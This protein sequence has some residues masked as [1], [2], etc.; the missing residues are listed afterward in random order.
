MHSIEWLCFRADAPDVQLS[1]GINERNSGDLQVAVASADDYVAELLTLP[2]VVH[3][4]EHALRT[5]HILWVVDR[6]R[7]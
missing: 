4:V 2:V 5:S 1:N 3:E 7:V 6:L